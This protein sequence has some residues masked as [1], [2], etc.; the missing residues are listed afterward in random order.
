[1]RAQGMSYQEIGDVIGLHW[2]RVGQLLK[3]ANEAID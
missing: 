3:S 2:T 1:M